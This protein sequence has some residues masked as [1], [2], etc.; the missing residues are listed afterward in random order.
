MTTKST[1][2]QTSL[3][4]QMLQF[5]IGEKKHDIILMIY[6][7]NMLTLFKY[8]FIYSLHVPVEPHEAV[9]EVSRIGNV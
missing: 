1:W 2:Q 9:A 6:N 4:T 3:F 7:Y 8:L 5:W